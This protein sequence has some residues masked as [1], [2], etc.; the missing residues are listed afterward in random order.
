MGALDGVMFSNTLKLHTC[1]GW[2]GILIEGLRKNFLNLEINVQ[3]LRP[4]N[5]VIHHAAVCTPPSYFVKFEP[6]IGNA[7]GGD[8]AE[9][10]PSFRKGW[11]NGKHPI[12]HTPCA[13]M[14]R[15]L[16]NTTHVDFFSLDVEGAELTVLETI[17]FRKVVISTFMIEMDEHA[18]HR[19]YKIRQYLFNMGY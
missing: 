18:L 1:L 14:S 16:E 4:E 19:N 5:T 3:K 10:S 17:D 15:F 11:H 13:P 2:S 8:I 9:M 7:V 12:E 6:G